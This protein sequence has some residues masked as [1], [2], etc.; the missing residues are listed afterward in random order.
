MEDL[1]YQTHNSIA[2]LGSLWLY[3]SFW[4]FKGIYYFAY[5][6]IYNK[7]FASKNDLEGGDPTQL[8]GGDDTESGNT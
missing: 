7:Y 4:I 5:G 6:F 8:E 2:I 1:G 3:I